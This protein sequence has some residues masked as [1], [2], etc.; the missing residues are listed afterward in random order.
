MVGICSCLV[1]LGLGGRE[2]NFLRM[3]HVGGLVG[4][5]ISLQYLCNTVFVRFFT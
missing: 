5:F 3:C 2:E 4:T 1:G